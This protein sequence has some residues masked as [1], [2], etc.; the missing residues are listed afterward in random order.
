MVSFATGLDVNNPAGWPA[1]KGQGR[2]GVSLCGNG[3]A[4]VS[5]GRIGAFGQSLA[6]AFAL[7][8]GPAGG[9]CLS[10]DLGGFPGRFVALVGELAP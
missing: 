8:S 4:L 7:G 3:N 5:F 9:L 10:G 1:G 6:L 2:T